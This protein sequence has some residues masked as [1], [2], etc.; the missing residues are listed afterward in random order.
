MRQAAAGA[1]LQVRRQ[2]P[3]QYVEHRREEQA[4][5]RHPEHPGE[6]RDAHRLAHFRSGAAGHDQRHHAG[7]ERQRGHQDRP[8]AQAAS[9]DHRLQR[10][11]AL[12]LQRAGELD[13]Q[14]RVLRRQAYQHH[15]PDLDEHVVVAAHQPHPGDRAEQAH[16]HDQQDRQRQQPAVV[17][18]GED[19][20]GQQHAQR[21]DEQR[22]VAGQLL[23]VGQV[24]PFEGHA[25]GQHFAGQALHQR[26][27]L[28]RTDAG[29]RAAADIRRRIAVVVDHPVGTG[30]G[31]HGDER[32]QRQHRP[33]GIAYLQ[34]PDGFGLHAVRRIGLG[35]DLVGAT[36][37]VEVV[38][39]Q[40]AEV[41]LQCLEHIG[42][43]NALAL[44]LGAVDHH[45]ELRG[46]DIE[47][48]HQAPELAGLS[49][50]HHQHLGLP[51]QGFQ[52]GAAAILDLHL[53]AADGSQPRY[54]RRREDPEEAVGNAGEPGLQAPGDG[55]RAEIGGGARFE[56]IEH[57][58]HDRGVRHVDETVHRQARKG[59]DALHPRLVEAD[60]GH[61]P[62]H[63]IGTLQR[64]SVRQLGDADQIVLVLHRHEARRHRLETDPGQ[65]KQAP[66]H[67]QGQAAHP[68][69]LAHR[70]AVGLGG[71]SQRSAEDLEQ[72]LE[73]P[74]HRTSGRPRTQQQDPPGPG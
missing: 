57:E 27:R 16:R 63:R 22:A 69:H 31:R 23:L 51:G 9:L 13:D 35:S 2:C 37:A 25:L 12:G 52:P 60:P 59:H 6:Y 70:V 33:G 43:A 68:H 49:G 53:E 3:Y 11:G 45:L 32:G 7:D 18:R 5:Q 41:D 55:Q 36:E 56:R 67:H 38:D 17:L 40:R 21:E 54:R 65:A 10:T 47:A 48:G 46:I 42:Q 30:A 71:I 19:Q 14:D 64:R 29:K 74:R 8:Q 26:H 15:Q 44:H 39:V 50:L 4:E 20:V 24:G 62:D 1:S 34:A 72:S 58:E 73:A 28:S 66:I 61:L